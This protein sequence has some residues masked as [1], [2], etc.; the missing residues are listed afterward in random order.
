MEKLVVQALIEIPQGCQNKYEIDKKSGRIKLD[1]TL[2][3]AMLY[4]GEY[5]YIENTLAK[6]GDPIDIL[7]FASFPTVPGCL[8]D[9][10]II[11]V[12]EMEDSGEEDVKLIG[13]SQNDP[14][15]NH[16][17]CLEELPPHYLIE[18]RSFF[19]TYK[20]LNKKEVITGRYLG[21]EDAYYYL[22]DAR[23]RYYEQM[24]INENDLL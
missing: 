3:S 5:G 22:N 6:D 7:V 2:Y 14:R 12:L 19:D 1:R 13:V 21:V 17:S 24:K 18:V 4:P 11:G 8:M 16:I 10:R 23:E 15:Y 20:L 9:V